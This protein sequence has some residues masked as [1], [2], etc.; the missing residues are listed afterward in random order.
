M[1]ALSGVVAP[2]QSI[3]DAARGALT[4]DPPPAGAGGYPGAT[5]GAAP[6][7]INDVGAAFGKIGTA[8]AGRAGGVIAP[9]AAA[10]LAPVAAN[11]FVS[12]IVVD[13]GSASA[14]ALFDDLQEYLK[15][16][17]V[18]LGPFDFAKSDF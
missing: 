5:P 4:P 15:T 9:Y 2:K 10:A 16:H 14:A 12:A 1:G 18:S 3:G 17:N 6:T 8:A 11:A 13:A 7:E